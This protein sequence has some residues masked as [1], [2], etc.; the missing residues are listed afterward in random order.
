MN[1]TCGSEVYKNAS[2]Q[3]WSSSFA[4]KM[5]YGTSICF[6]DVLND[7]IHIFETSELKLDMNNTHLLLFI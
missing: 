5:G 4:S 3:L 7:K 6:R 1:A 2:N